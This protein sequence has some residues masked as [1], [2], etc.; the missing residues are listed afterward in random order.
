MQVKLPADRTVVMVMKCSDTLAAMRRL[1]AQVS[2][3]REVGGVWE[4]TGIYCMA[5]MV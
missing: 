2:G 5:M 1:V 3:G 4:A